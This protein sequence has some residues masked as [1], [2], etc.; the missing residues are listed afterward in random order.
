MVKLCRPVDFLRSR[1]AGNRSTEVDAAC[2]SEVDD[3]EPSGMRHRV[4]TTDRVELVDDRGD[5]KLCRVDGD[6]EPPR[7]RLVRRA[8]GE[9]RQHLQFARGERNVDRRN[10]HAV[11]LQRERELLIRSLNRACRGHNDRVGRIARGNE[12]QARHSRKQCGKPIGERPIR[13][14]KRKPDRLRSVLVAQAVGLSPMVSDSCFV[15][16]ARRR[17]S[18]TVCPTRSGPNALNSDWTCRIGSPFK[19]TMTSP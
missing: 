13:D 14:V 10:A 9:Q 2:G 8:F 11:I 15:S 4:G 3:A 16:P 18:V 1:Y 19:A 12:T 5:V 6:R 17:S 7:D